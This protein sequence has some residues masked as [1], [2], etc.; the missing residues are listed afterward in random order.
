MKIFVVG[1][2]RGISNEHSLQVFKKGGKV[3]T[4][5][6]GCCILTLSGT[7]GNSLDG[8]INPCPAEPGQAL[9]LITV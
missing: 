8:F 9:P 2:H 5:P 1:F 3:K 4:V 7:N 6:N